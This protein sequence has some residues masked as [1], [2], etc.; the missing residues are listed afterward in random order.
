MNLCFTLDGM[1]QAKSSMMSDS[2]RCNEKVKV[3]VTIQMLKWESKS[4]NHNEILTSFNVKQLMLLLCCV[5]VLHCHKGVT[6]SLSGSCM[7]QSCHSFNLGIKRS[8]LLSSVT[9]MALLL[10]NLLFASLLFLASGLQLE[11]IANV[12]HGSDSSE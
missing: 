3:R 6:Q 5:S 7:S 4:E 1:H 8:Q 2:F 9:I 12:K 10:R 11:D